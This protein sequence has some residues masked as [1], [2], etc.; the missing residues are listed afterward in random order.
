MSLLAAAVALAASLCVILTLLVPATKPSVAVLD[1]W[2]R[3]LV[4]QEE[5]AIADDTADSRIKVS[6]AGA[7]RSFSSRCLGG[8]FGRCSASL[9]ALKGALAGTLR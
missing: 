9:L 4:D 5:P 6:F 8:A 2:A 7:R 3:V 1:V